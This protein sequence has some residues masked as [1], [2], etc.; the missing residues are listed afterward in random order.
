MVYPAGAGAPKL[1][2]HDR[3]LPVPLVRSGRRVDDLPSLEQSRE[4]LRRNLKSLPWEGL[5]LTQ[6]DPAVPIVFA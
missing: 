4:L 1:G 6:G 3:V 2:D 5:S